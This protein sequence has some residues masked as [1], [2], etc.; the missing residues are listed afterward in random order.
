MQL[1]NVTSGACTR[2][3][4]KHTDAV[5]DMRFVEQDFYLI[6]GSRDKT[7]RVWNVY[8]GACEHTLTGH[9]D[10]VTAVEVISRVLASAS[11]DYSVRLWSLDTFA[12]IKTLKA[13]HSSWILSLLV[14]SPS[15]FA[16]ASLDQTIKVWSVSSGGDPL[17]TINNADFK[18]YYSLDWYKYYGSHVIAKLA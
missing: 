15:E 2:T 8:S 16:S 11:N 12:L 18:S 14:L 9:S 3:L 17:I 5:L 4:T 13:A 10:S 6:S 1:W 7:V